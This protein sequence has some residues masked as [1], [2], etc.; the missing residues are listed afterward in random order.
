MNQISSSSVLVPH[1]EMEFLQN[2]PKA[3]VIYYLRT[4]LKRATF[5]ESHKGTK[6]IM[7]SRKVTNLNFLHSILRLSSCLLS[8][9]FLL[10]T[11]Y[12]NCFPFVLGNVKRDSDKRKHYPFPQTIHEMCKLPTTSSDSATSSRL[13]KPSFNCFP[14]S[15]C[16]LCTS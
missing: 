4:F 10:F 5:P 15:H 2:S 1:I 8:F 3:S 9:S 7:E 14:S 6:T 12:L 11:S 16:G 13:H